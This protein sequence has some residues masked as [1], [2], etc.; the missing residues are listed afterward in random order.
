MKSYFRLFYR[1]PG[2]PKTYHRNDHTSACED[3]ARLKLHRTHTEA[4][5]IS[6]V[7]HVQ[8]AEVQKNAEDRRG[9]SGVEGTPGA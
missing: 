4:I 9:P 5:E 8:D 6:S 1:L 2:D 7:I 3:S